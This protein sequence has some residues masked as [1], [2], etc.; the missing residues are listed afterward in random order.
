MCKYVCINSIFFSK[1]KQKKRILKQD[2]HLMVSLSSSC[3]IKTILLPLYIH[4][5]AYVSSRWVWCVCVSVYCV[6]FPWWLSHRQEGCEANPLHTSR[7]PGLGQITW[8]IVMTQTWRGHSGTTR[9]SRNSC[10]VNSR[11]CGWIGAVHSGPNCAHSRNRIQTLKYC[12]YNRI[13]CAHLEPHWATIVTGFCEVSN[14]PGTLHTPGLSAQITGQGRIVVT[15]KNWG[16][17]RVAVPM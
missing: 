17:I 8:W 12:L 6:W 3:S 4:P 7:V 2:S 11:S 16:S 5:C 13:Y 1:K 14:S 15:P 9:K 10:E